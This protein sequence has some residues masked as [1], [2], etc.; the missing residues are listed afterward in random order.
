[1]NVLERFSKSD[2]IMLLKTEFGEHKVSFSIQNDGTAGV[3]VKKANEDRCKEIFLANGF[4]LVQLKH[5]TRQQKQEHN[6]YV[7][8]T[9]L[10]FLSKEE[11][12]AGEAKLETVFSNAEITKKGVVICSKVSSK[13]L[14]ANEINDLLKFLSLYTY[15]FK[16]VKREQ[17]E[18]KFIAKWKK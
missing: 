12:K 10:R 15:D 1:M 9:D 6:F 18:T 14:G 17:T 4:E 7:F 16:A 5:L 2:I 8:Y 11:I 13:Y 3:K